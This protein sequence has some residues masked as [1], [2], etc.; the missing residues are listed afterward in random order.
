MKNMLKKIVI[1]VVIGIVLMTEAKADVYSTLF[2]VEKVDR[3][4]DVAIL[5]DCTGHEWLYTEP[6]DMEEDDFYTA[7]MDDNGTELVY[8]DVIISIRYERPDMF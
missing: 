3:I 7:V 1:L 6:E 8:D 5:V 2:K 4:E